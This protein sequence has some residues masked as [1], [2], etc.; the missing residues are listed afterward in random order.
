MI[1]SW[2]P[3]RVWH[4]KAVSGGMPDAIALGTKCLPSAQHERDLH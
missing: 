2:D 1:P 3:N 4:S